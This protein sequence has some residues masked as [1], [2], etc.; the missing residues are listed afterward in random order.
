VQ[1]VVEMLQ[2][3]LAR[4]MGMCGRPTLAAVDSSVLRVHAPLPS[5]N[6]NHG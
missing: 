6:N 5:V 2:T 4:Y 1:G 3:E